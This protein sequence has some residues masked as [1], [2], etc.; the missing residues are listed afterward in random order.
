[1]RNLRKRYCYDDRL[2]MQDTINDLRLYILYVLLQR[3]HGVCAICKQPAS[4]YD[5]DHLIYN[6]MI[7][8]N[9]LQALCIPCHK[10]ITNYTAMRYR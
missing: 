3:Q 2:E 1:M 7:T 8:V 6:P 5:I 9:E 10:S 4:K